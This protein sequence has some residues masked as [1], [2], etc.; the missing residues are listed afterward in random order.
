MYVKKY[1]SNGLLTNPITKEQ[2]FLNRGDNRKSR[3]LLKFPQRKSNNKAGSGCVV[4]RIGAMTFTRYQIVKQHFADR[5][6]IHSI[7]R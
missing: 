3:R 1:D 5:T 2:P 6:I 7:L 4:T